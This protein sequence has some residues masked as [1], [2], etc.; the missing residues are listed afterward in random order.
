MMKQLIIVPLTLLLIGMAS[1]CSSGG[2]E[3]IRTISINILPQSDYA[4]ILHGPDSKGRYYYSIANTAEGAAERYGI[5]PF[6]S[7][8]IDPEVAPVIQQE[9]PGVYRVTLGNGQD[10]EFVVVDTLQK[11]IVKDS[12][13]ENSTNR[14]FKKEE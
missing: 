14:P 10:A 9:A 4:V 1:S 11:R 8:T 12:N 13:P 7:G 3:T 5:W 2:S 6:G